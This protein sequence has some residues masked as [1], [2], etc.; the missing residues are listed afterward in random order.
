[1]DTTLD[2]VVEIAEAARRTLYYPV[3]PTRPV[4]VISESNVAYGARLDSYAA[5]VTAY[6]KAFKEYRDAVCAIDEAFRTSL[7]EALGVAK[8][9]NAM[10]MY[11]MAWAYGHSSGYREVA[12]YAEE[13]ATLLK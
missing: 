7:L 5:M 10:K 2:S 11:N 3:T 6:R 8:H 12:D 9:P 13:L 4:K 1:M